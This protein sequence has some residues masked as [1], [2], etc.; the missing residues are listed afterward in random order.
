MS[1][2]RGPFAVCSIPVETTRAV[3][4]HVGRAGGAAAADKDETPRADKDETPRAV[5]KSDALGATG[6]ESERTRRLGDG[7]VAPPGEIVVAVGSVA[8]LGEIVVV[9]VAFAFAASTAACALLRSQLPLSSIRIC[10]SD[11]M[12]IARSA[13][14]PTR[15]LAATTRPSPY[16]ERSN[17]SSAVS[18][19]RRGVP[20]TAPTPSGRDGVDD[21]RDGSGRGCV[22]VK[23]RLNASMPW[24]HS[25]TLLLRTSALTRSSAP[26]SMVEASMGCAR[27]N[28]GASGVS[29][30]DA[31]V[32][33]GGWRVGVGSGLG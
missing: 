29:D 33:D 23:M 22:G 10:A 25:W 3:G 30:R 28:E 19:R 27:R 11:T 6:I 20:S 4:T 12:T 1:A 7:S 9:V 18:T 17:R 8:R 26:T 14:V 15:L 2:F 32:E 31:R 5:G 16:A 24:R 21:G 13:S